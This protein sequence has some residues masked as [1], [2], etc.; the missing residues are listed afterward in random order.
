MNHARSCFKYLSFSNKVFLKIKSLKKKKKKKKCYA[1]MGVWQTFTVSCNADGAL[2]QSR[3]A[4]VLCLHLSA[5]LQFITS[6]FVAADAEDFS[7]LCLLCGLQFSSLFSEIYI[8][9]KEKKIA[10]ASV[11]SSLINIYILLK[12]KIVLKTDGA[13]IM[14]F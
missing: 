14:D 8:T 13:V 6:L 7:F 4:L 1:R 12:K 3:A 11:F 9:G 2:T 10:F 5:L